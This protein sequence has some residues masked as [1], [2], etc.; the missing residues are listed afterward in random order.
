MAELIPISEIS[1]LRPASEVKAVADEAMQIIEKE[2][3]ARLINI[4]ANSGQHSAIW[5]H[6]MSAEVKTLV[7]G[8]GYR[9]TRVPR[10]ADPNVMWMIE[11]F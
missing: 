7:E 1:V 9:V 11:G 8:Q 5:E 6:P 2:S 4:A 3:I 10:A